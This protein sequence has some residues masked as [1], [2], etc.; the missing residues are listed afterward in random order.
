MVQE[1]YSDEEER[2]ASPADEKKIFSPHQRKILSNAQRNNLNLAITKR[3]SNW[4][5]VNS[6]FAQVNRR[7]IIKVISISLLG[8]ISI[9]SLV[10]GLLVRTTK[11]VESYQ[12]DKVALLASYHKIGNILIGAASAIVFIIVLY[13][14]L[15]KLL[16]NLTNKKL[17]AKDVYLK[18]TDCETIKQPSKNKD[19]YERHTI[20]YDENMNPIFLKIEKYALSSKNFVSTKPMDTQ[21]IKICESTS[22]E[23]RDTTSDEIRG[24]IKKSSEN[25]RD[26]VFSLNVRPKF[27]NENHNVLTNRLL[28]VI[29]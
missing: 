27:Q 29:E 8:W 11:I 13:A 16:N 6:F 1:Y 22:D 23:I 26:F 18:I 9:V 28:S 4:L 3:L 7:T 12:G 24:I 15:N 10:V 25:V 21:K 14:L 2:E 5:S 20:S 19:D 17:K